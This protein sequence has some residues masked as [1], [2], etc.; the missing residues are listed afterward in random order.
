MLLTAVAVAGCGGPA[1][2]APKT[3][4]SWGATAQRA[5]EA[6]LDGDVPRAYVVRTLHTAR[7]ELRDARRAVAGG[8][9]AAMNAAA[10]LERVRVLEGG[11]L[12]LSAAV[13]ARNRA[14][15]A[16]AVDEVAAATR[17]VAPW[18]RGAAGS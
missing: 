11:V 5:G 18:V 15:A 2:K 14:A 16:D 1:S 17:A 4:L 12:H 6:W 13:A 3:A 10:L 7:S 9:P 8:A